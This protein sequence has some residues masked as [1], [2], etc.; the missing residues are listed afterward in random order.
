MK[1]FDGPPHPG[2]GSLPR[3][4]ASVVVVGVG[5]A[6]QRNAHQKVMV[7]EEIGPGG[8]QPPAVCLDGVVDRYP[9]P[10]VT[11]LQL[12]RLFVEIQPHQGGFAPLEGDGTRPFG[13]G[14]R[15]PDH[16]F[17]RCFAH[18]SA[19]ALPAVLHLIAVKAVTAAKVAGPRSGLE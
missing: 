8:V 11:G 4:V 19:D 16:P 13:F 1:Q 15:R 3:G 12:H 9:R 7:P 2:K 5:G 10:G 14:Q 17:Q 6:V 18:T